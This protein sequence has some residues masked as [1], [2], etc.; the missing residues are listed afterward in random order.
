MTRRLTILIV[1]VVLATLLLVGV[2]TLVLA[3]VR[4]R[5]TTERRAAR[6][7]R[8]ASRRAST[9]RST[10][11]A[12][13][14]PAQLR[15]RLRLVRSFGAVL[16]DRRRRRARS[17]APAAS[18][19]ATDLPDGHRAS[20][21][22]TRRARRAADGQRQPRQH[23]VGRGADADQQRSA[24]RRRAD[25]RGQRRRS[26]RRC[27]T[28]SWPRAVDARARRASSR[29]CLGRRLT[30][31][32]RDASAATQR[33]AAGEL[34]TRVEPTA[35]PTTTTSWPTCCAASTRWPTG[36]ERSKVLGA[37]V[38]AVGQP[39][40]AHAA[41]V[42]PRLRRGDQRRRR[43]TGRSRRRHPVRVTPARA[44]RRR[45]A[46]PGQA[47]EP[48]LLAAPG[49]ARPACRDAPRPCPASCPMR[50]SATSQL[51]MQRRCQPVP[52]DRRS[53]RLAQVAANL[54]ENAL[55]YARFEVDRHRR[56]AG[57]GR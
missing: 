19:T 6:S 47:A 48:Q 55:T 3:N 1:G 38:P 25:P 42:D 40:P 23:G 49:A 53:D 27:A 20:T 46:R 32:I 30:R 41:D 14:D 16:A 17:P 51:Q 12:I 8:G 15:R 13:T 57:R 11:S 18:S 22:S 26:A 52:V 28:S 10:S 4:A 5:H 37:A 50:P 54:V 21:T 24:R 31:R 33:I 44:A 29:S 36:L 43:R 45:P 35:P 2:G 56:S 39:R 7:G 34:S 9:T